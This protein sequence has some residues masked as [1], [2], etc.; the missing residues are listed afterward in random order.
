MASDVHR[1]GQY[2]RG[3]PLVRSK[4]NA[5]AGGPGGKASRSSWVLVI[6]EAKNETVSGKGVN[7]IFNLSDFCQICTLSVA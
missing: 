3:R 2:S 4:G 5:L 1:T 6:L 7:F